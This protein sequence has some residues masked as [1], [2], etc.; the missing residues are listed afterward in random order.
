MSKRR[1]IIGTALAAGAGLAYWKWR[2]D[3][4]LPPPDPGPPPDPDPEPA[5]FH[6]IVKSQTSGAR[7]SGVAITGKGSWFGAASWS[8]V[9]DQDGSFYIPGIVPG[10]HNAT[11]SYPRHV[12]K[13]ISLWF[14]S[15][16]PEY[17]DIALKHELDPSPDLASLGGYVEGDP[18]GYPDKYYRLAGAVVD[19]GGLWSAITD[20]HGLFF[21][22]NIEPG[23]YMTTVSYA[24]YTP[25]TY[26]STFKSGDARSTGI[27]LRPVVESESDIRIDSLTA[28][29]DAATVR[30]RISI[31]NYGTEDGDAIIVWSAPASGYYHTAVFNVRAGRTTGS[32]LTLGAAT[33]P[34]PGTYEL[35]ANDIMATFTIPELVFP[36]PYCDLEFGSQ[37][38]LEFHVYQVHGQTGLIGDL[39]NDGILDQGDIDILGSYIHGYPISEISPLSEE[40]F[41]RRADVNGDGR[42]NIQDIFALLKLINEGE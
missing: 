28:T 2:K 29:A 14:V 32:E 16:R 31:T 5:S 27:R 15:G 23:T 39:N 22:D 1:V 38:D 17:L 21:I 4:V 42:I 35:Y 18:N 40:E 20:E 9:T 8:G 10:R 34:G 30:A 12:S 13:E 33:F 3:S 7:L 6:G 36:C 11:F 24:G 19:I 41:L 26:S 25:R 37:D